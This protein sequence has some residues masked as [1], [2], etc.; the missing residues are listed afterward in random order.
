METPYVRALTRIRPAPKT[1]VRR[2]ISSIE[3]LISSIEKLISSIEKLISSG[4]SVYEFEYVSVNE[5]EFVYEFEKVAQKCA[6]RF[7]RLFL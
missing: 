7:T 6:K 4:V 1:E 5:F 3:K 2:R